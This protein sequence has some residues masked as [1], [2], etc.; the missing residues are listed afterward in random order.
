[1]GAVAGAVGDRDVAPGQGGE[2]MVQA[3]LVGLHDP[4]V[5]G[6]LLSDQPVGV[7]ALGVER[8][9]SDHGI[10]ELQAVQQRPELGD[11]VGLAV[12]PGLAQD[13]SG[14]VVHHRQQMHLRGAVVA[15]AAQG[16]AVDRDRP[17]RR[18]ARRRQACWWGWLLAGQPGT[19][20]AVQRV[21]VDA[22]QDPAHGRLRW[23]LPGAGQRVSAHPKRGQHLPGRV[24]GPLTDGGQR[25]RAGQHRA[26]CDAEHADQWMSS[27]APVAGVGDLGEVAEQV[28]ALVGC[29]R[30]GRSQPLGSRRN[31]G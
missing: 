21:G 2:V 23:W 8:I 29:Q 26:D 14:G 20:G 28:T 27:A 9:G 31:G 3:G 11:L 10:G 25:P 16:L 5:G 24:A 19:D 4:Q 30:G 7:L 13:A 17:M 18:V 22:G 1:V 15:A 6:V 12:H